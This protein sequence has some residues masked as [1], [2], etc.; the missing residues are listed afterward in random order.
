MPRRDDTRTRTL[1]V[2]GSKSQTQRA[3]I[4]AALARGE[5]SLHGALDCDDSR[6]L[7]RG[8][9]SLGIQITVSDTDGRTWRVHG[10]GGELEPPRD[11]IDCGEA[12]TTLRFLA[13]LSLLVQGDGELILD[14]SPRL[15][16]RPLKP[17]LRSLSDLG[18]RV[19]HVENQGSL[20]V[21]LRHEGET[22][23]D[24]PSRVQIASDQSSQFAS[25]LLMA[26]P[27]LPGGLTLEMSGGADR[28]SLPYVELTLRTMATFGVQVQV[29]SRGDSVRVPR[30]SYRPTDLQVEGDWSGAAFLLVGGAISGQTIEIDNLDPTSVQGDRA[31]VEFLAELR[32]PQPHRFDLT[33]CPDLI[34]PLAVACA[35]AAEHPSEIV[36]AAHARL[37]E[38]DRLAVLAQGLG[39]AGVSVTERA[40][41][42]H[43]EPVKKLTPTPDALDPRGDHR[44]AM[45]FGLLTLREPRLQ[46]L[47]PGCV[48]KSFPD[49]WQQLERLRRR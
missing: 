21:G 3:L 18:V 14:G 7:R 40:E 16:E 26:A 37:K 46:V 35:L 22:A 19:R 24:P 23:P 38:S 39:R 41:G 36:G 27:L 20:P 43:V 4:L 15:R 48:S 29:S 32:R 42:L 30:G 11:P 45:A 31:I 5:S 17:L 8:L 25:G 10:T 6:A 49:F 28:V 44:M 2:P 9:E 33:H 34:A 13:P 47:D 12:G 1:Q